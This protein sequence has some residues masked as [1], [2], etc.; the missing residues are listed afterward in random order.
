MN[1]IIENKQY[2]FKTFSKIPSRDELTFYYKNKYFKEDKNY[3]QE[4]ADY[5]IENKIAEANFLLDV[6]KNKV[7]KSLNSIIEIGSGEGFFLKSALDRELSILGIDFDKK[8]IHKSNQ[9]CSKYFIA[10]DDPVN[11]A[12]SK[13]RSPSCLVLRH[14]IEHVPNPLEILDVIA[15]NLV[16]GAVIV[17]EAP[18]DFKS[19][20]KYLINNS[21][22]DNEYWVS[23]PEHLSYFEPK[24]IES[25]L[26]D[27][28][29]KIVESYSDFPIELALLSDHLNYSKNRENGRKMHNFR[30]RVNSYLYKEKDI[31]QIL[32]IYKAMHNAGL[33]R[34]FTIIAERVM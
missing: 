17:I 28:G 1:S 25:I 12:F 6:L 31:N 24:H 5:E 33:G 18:H 34:S 2:G 3:N 10:T 13:N 23:H 14:V 26:K 19:L 8:Q 7:S 16:R 30:C 4:L 21:L 29:F 27:R 9:S 15:R 20:Q 32:G 22:V 11:E